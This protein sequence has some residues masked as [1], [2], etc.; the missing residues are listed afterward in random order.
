LETQLL[1]TVTGE[2]EGKEYS[3]SVVGELDEDDEGGDKAEGLLC[4]DVTSA[5]VSI[6]LQASFF[7]S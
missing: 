1:E 6:A 3:P 5:K 4:E 2:E 7:I